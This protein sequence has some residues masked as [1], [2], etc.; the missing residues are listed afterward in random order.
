MLQEI[1]DF[2]VKKKIK[3]HE[4]LSM[5]IHCRLIPIIGILSS[6]IIIWKTVTVGTIWC[7]KRG[8]TDPLEKVRIYFDIFQMRS[9][10]QTTLTRSRWVGSH[11]IVNVHMVENV[12]IVGPPPTCL[13]VKRTL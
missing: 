5:K 7:S 9:H 2:L 4:G 3:V 10:T 8:T 12:N 11:L 6:A 1:K 13:P